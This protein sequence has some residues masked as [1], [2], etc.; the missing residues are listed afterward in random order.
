MM[1]GLSEGEYDGLV[2]GL[3][4]DGIRVGES[5]LGVLVA[6]LEGLTLESEE[7][8]GFVDGMMIIVLDADM[9]GIEVV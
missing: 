3:R 1:L 6:G 9:V 4:V 7:L 8:E 2:L 5:M